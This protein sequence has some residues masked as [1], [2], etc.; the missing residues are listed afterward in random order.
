MV[1]FII[2]AVLIGVIAV[3]VLRKPFTPP[4]S[5]HADPKLFKFYEAAPSVFVNAPER[6]FFQMCSKA[7][8][9]GYVLLAKP[10]LEDIIR[11]KRDLPNPKLRWQLRARVKSRHIDFAIMRWDGTP[12]MGI[13]LDGPSHDNSAANAGD[14]LK[15]GIFRAA[16]LPLR[17]IQ[18]GE[19]FAN[20]IAEITHFLKSP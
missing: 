2:I 4:P 16:G 11:V 13:E 19:D 7:L 9:K 12:V 6:I 20:H 10:R 1:E 5:T 3:A 14:A 15:D 8:P 17:R 18:T